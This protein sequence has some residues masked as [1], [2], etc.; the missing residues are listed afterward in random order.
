MAPTATI[1]ERAAGTIVPELVGEYHQVRRLDTSTEEMRVLV[2]YD[3][4]TYSFG[5]EP[6]GY[7]E[8]G[9]VIADQASIKFIA[10]SSTDPDHSFAGRGTAQWTVGPGPADYG[11]GSVLSLSFPD[12][13]GYGYGGYDQGV[14][15]YFVSN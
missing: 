7:Q 5:I 14:D 13:R 15:V 6:V 11:P 4:A 8:Q 10:D 9:S 3:D 2:L 12:G 1:Q